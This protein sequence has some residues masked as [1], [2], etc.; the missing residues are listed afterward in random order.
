MFI[1]WYGESKKS[2]RIAKDDA[3][4]EFIAACHDLFYVCVIPFSIIVMEEA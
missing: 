3:I 2:N 4:I 1:H